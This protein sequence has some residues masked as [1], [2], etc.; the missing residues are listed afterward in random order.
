MSLQHVSIAAQPS[1][2]CVPF[3]KK[4]DNLLDYLGNRHT[5]HDFQNDAL[6]W[7]RENQNVA[8]YCSHMIL[9]EL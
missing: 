7:T 6:K 5:M 4:L 3:S 8:H 2:L 1:H 9:H